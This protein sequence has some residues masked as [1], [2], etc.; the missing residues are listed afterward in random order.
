MNTSNDFGKLVKHR[1]IDIG[2][3]QAWLIEQVRERTGMYCDS[4]LC[5]RIYHGETAGKVKSA[6]CEILEIKEG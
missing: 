1:L 4:S 5:N 2:K 3:N 6:I